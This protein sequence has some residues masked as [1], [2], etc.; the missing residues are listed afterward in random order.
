MRLSDK[1]FKSMNNVFRRLSQRYIEFRTF[2]DFLEGCRID[3]HN[4]TIIDAGCGS[5]YS[6]ELILD[7]YK[8]SDIIAFDLMPEQIELA[9]KRNLNVDFHTGDMTQMEIEDGYAD[10][11]FVFG[12][13]H[14]IPE[15]KA[16]LREI[17][18]VLK[19]NG[20]LLVEEP[21]ER[22]TWAELEDGI[23]DS[24]LR[25]IK[26]KKIFFGHLKCYLC[27]KMG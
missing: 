25:I 5:G 19:T 10:G 14:H 21:E 15:W 7:E 13:L 18:R 26:K 20:V 1:E 23:R 2:K 8:P 27:Q 9:L 3:L 24:G 22:L 4:K 11:V 6:T 12:V 17:A 16:A